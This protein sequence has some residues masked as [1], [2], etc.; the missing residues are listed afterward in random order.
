MKE[1]AEVYLPVIVAI[2]VTVEYDP[3]TEDP[4]ELAMLKAETEVYQAAGNSIAA[5]QYS[6]V[7]MRWQ[8]MDNIV[9][10]KIDVYNKA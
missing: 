9:E 3:E 5:S 4:V 2:T 10:D 1:T 8:G 6:G 7:S